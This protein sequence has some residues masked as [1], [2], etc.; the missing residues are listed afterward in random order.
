M[1]TVAGREKQ[2]EVVRGVYTETRG[3]EGKKPFLTHEY[4]KRNE[5]VIG[6]DSKFTRSFA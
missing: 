2:G 6:M 5:R 4:V 3:G 1:G